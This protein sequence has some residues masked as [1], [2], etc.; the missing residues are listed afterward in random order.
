MVKSEQL[1]LPIPEIQVAAARAAIPRAHR[2]FVN[3]SLKMASI[4]WIGFDMDYTLATY[5]RAAMDSLCVGIMIDRLRAR[6]L[7]PFVSHVDVD[8]SFPIRGLV[9]DRRLGHVLKLDRYRLVQKGYHGLHA[10]SQ[11]QLRKSYEARR[12]RL[13]TPRYHGVDTLYGLSE[14]A[15]FAALVHEFDRQ[16]SPVDYAHVFEQVRDCADSAYRDGTVPRQIC[17]DLSRFVRRDPLLAP[18]LHKLRSAG[19]RLFLLTNSPW[20]FTDAVMGHLLGDVMPEYPTW[21]HYFDVV[22]TSAS[23][24]E[25][26]QERRPL[27]E[28]DGESRRTVSLRASMPLERGK[29]YEGGNLFDLERMLGVT[30]DQVL[31]VGDHIYGDI[32][33]SKKEASWRT[34]LVLQELDA[35]IAAHESSLEDIQRLA[36][37]AARRGEL[38]DELRANQTLFKDQSRQIESTRATRDDALALAI[39]VHRQRV[40]RTV[41]RVRGLLKQVDGET[42]DIEARI[43][44]R[45]HPYWGA[46]LKEGTELSCYGDQVQAY[47]CVYTSQ[48]S[49]LLSY[50]PVQHFRS[51]RD[52]MPHEM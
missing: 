46:L 20:D 4:D 51:P 40:K 32:L 44:Q 8:P 11:D 33:R 16:A 1:A 52:L 41:D 29:A 18:T 31:Y 10:L 3:R 36:E 14:T 13:G 25:F 42:H 15:L 17:A 24:P 47:A 34:A 43:D 6:G 19:K 37:L 45:F 35:E 2:V 28:R 26:F 38:E 23:K 30:G 22:I 27:L 50:S 5:E 7:P 39:E 49:N 12:I 21:R 48:V 9:V